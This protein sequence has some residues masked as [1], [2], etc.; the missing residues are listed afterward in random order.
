MEL[1]A[2]K[3]LQA[4]E[5]SHQNCS[6]SGCV[7][8]EQLTRRSSGDVAVLDEP[9]GR[10]RR[11]EPSRESSQ[12]SLAGEGKAVSVG[13][14]AAGVLAS[15]SQP[16][17]TTTVT[18][19]G[20]V[21]PPQ[22]PV[23]RVV[24][25][26]Q[27]AILSNDN[28]Y[29]RTVSS[30]ARTSVRVTDLSSTTSKE[31]VRTSSEVHSARSGSEYGQAQ[32]TRQY[33]RAPEVRSF[34]FDSRSQVLDG[35]AGTVRT[36]EARLGASDT[37]RATT[38]V[39]RNDISPER[40][41]PTSSRATSVEAQRAYAVEV[42][43][44]SPQVAKYNDTSPVVR[45]SSPASQERLSG[46]R[47]SATDMATGT[48]RSE[49]ATIVTQHNSSATS[50]V[51]KMEPQRV[52]T[53]Q[54]MVRPPPIARTEEVALSVRS[55]SSVVQAPAR[56]PRPVRA[57]GQTPTRTVERVMSVPER[58]VAT[59]TLA[60][61]AEPQRSA[62]SS[63]LAARVEPQRVH[64]T[65]V[66][67]SSQ[68]LA[69]SAEALSAPRA[70]SA[71]LPERS[72]SIRPVGR[73]ASSRTG[74]G[75]RAS[76]V[77][78]RKPVTPVVAA[79][80]QRGGDT[81]IAAAPER[82]RVRHAASQHAAA[83]ERR[84]VEVLGRIQRVLERTTPSSQRGMTLS[85]LMKLEVATKILE[86]LDEE[87]YQGISELRSRPRLSALRR[88]RLSR[89]RGEKLREQELRK[90]KEREK[91]RKSKGSDGAQPS[92][93]ASL[94]PSGAGVAVKIAAPQ[95]GAIAKGSTPSKSLDI[96]QV[97]IDD[98]GDEGPRTPR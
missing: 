83:L 66:R 9:V 16:T 1:E 47:S 88:R 69:K 93:D 51:V 17:V 41:S 90:A 11:R 49:R 43:S 3:G 33:E 45:A 78:E 77:T 44:S 59:S 64:A 30:E 26:E 25:P 82:N 13:V 58:S 32:V 74:G 94:T 42:R 31:V 80:K 96:F 57:E 46:G 56:D 98:D 68:P 84:R 48:G 71:A 20:A 7:K 4:R 18:S 6:C 76:V 97:K 95:K 81:V 63:T 72:S 65:E 37:P 73:D 85:Q 62:P 34:S 35:R 61:R 29:T 60:A 19:G 8:A 86:L 5:A 2:R 50:G 87:E 40:T 53:A 52:Q 14:I 21:S 39:R 91:R 75:D 24:L 15:G 22:L 28:R 92:S 70:P 54:A 55:P 89:I 67:L 23:N 36:V 12:T 27:V 10:P 38:D 79:S